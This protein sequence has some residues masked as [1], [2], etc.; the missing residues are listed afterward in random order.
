ME[1]SLGN[2]VLMEQVVVFSFAPSELLGQEAMVMMAAP[3]SEME[4][5]E[6]QETARQTEGEDEVLI[7]KVAMKEVLRMV[8][9]VPLS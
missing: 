2:Q 1:G 3:P 4:L 9:K 8:V 7:V 5:V 6:R